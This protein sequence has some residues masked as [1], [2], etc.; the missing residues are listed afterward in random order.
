MNNLKGNPLLP[1][2]WRGN[3]MSLY[4]AIILKIDQFLELKLV[5]EMIIE[6][7]SI[8]LDISEIFSFNLFLHRHVRKN[9][10]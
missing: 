1:K 9:I 2:Y 10:L 4:Y 5:G 7:Y 3:H 6:K 8:R